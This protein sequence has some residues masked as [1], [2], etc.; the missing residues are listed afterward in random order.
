MST[1]GDKGVRIYNNSKVPREYRHGVKIRN[2]GMFIDSDS[3]NAS[4]W[5]ALINNPEYVDICPDGKRLWKGRLNKD[6]YAVVNTKILPFVPP[7]FEKGIDVPGHRLSYSLLIENAPTN[8]C[9]CHRS[10]VRNN[11][12]PNDLFLGTFAQNSAQIKMQGRRIYP[13]G[14][15]HW[16]AKLNEDKVVAIVHLYFSNV[17]T[18]GEIAEEFGVSRGTTS[19]VVNCRGPWEKV[20][21]M[22]KDAVIAV[23]MGN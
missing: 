9:V 17:V 2:L 1:S 6:G 3:K 15:D 20:A 8:A 4:F 11:L 22:A 5:S 10:N 14:Q 18:I 7:G 21:R 19:A 16:S 13:R 23:K 12:D